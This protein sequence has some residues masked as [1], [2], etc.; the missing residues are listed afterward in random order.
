MMARR[1]G[2]DSESARKANEHME[3]E[4]AKRRDNARKAERT[5][6]FLMLAVGAVFLLSGVFKGFVSIPRMVGQYEAAYIQYQEEYEAVKEEY[7]STGG[8]RVKYVQPEM[9][10]A[11][12]TGEAICSFQNQL[13]K[14]SYEWKASG[15]GKSEAYLECLLQYQNWLES[16][17]SSTYMDAWSERG[18]WRF[19]NTYDYVGEGTYVVWGC[20]GVSDSLRQ[21]PYMFAIGYY[22]PSSTKISDVTVY[23]TVYYDRALAEEETVVSDYVNGIPVPFDQEG[24]PGIGPPNDLGPAAHPEMTEG[25]TQDV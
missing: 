18:Q 14:Y 25:V 1:Y 2:A 6:G 22:N 21:R 19:D 11:R 23:R 16:S 9:N 3:A 10:S 12:Q 24:D 7:E 8:H 20:Y 13:T 5:V 4:Q 17:V 15:E